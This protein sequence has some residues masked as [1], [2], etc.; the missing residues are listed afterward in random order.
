MKTRFKTTIKQRKDGI[1]KLVYE[2][3]PI[4]SKNEK[5]SFLN[6]DDQGN[7]KILKFS[8]QSPE[9]NLD[10]VFYGMLDTGSD[11]SFYNEE[12]FDPEYT[13]RLPELDTVKI[14]LRGINSLTSW[15]VKYF[16]ATVVFKK[17]KFTNKF[18]S[19]SADRFPPGGDFVFLLGNDF[20]KKAG[21]KIV[22]EDN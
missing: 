15:K 14:H 19:V 7:K 5:K 22:Q 4:L 12:T 2:I 1:H 17:K 3:S 9:L 20:F 6:S 16:F 8:F 13:L 21:L 18:Y 11:A 10:T